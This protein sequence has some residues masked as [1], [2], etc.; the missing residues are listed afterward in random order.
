MNVWSEIRKENIHMNNSGYR[1]IIVDDEDIVRL[2]LVSFFEDEGFQVCSAQTGE[3]ALE[4]LMSQPCHVGIID[5]RLPKMDG[6][7]LILKAQ[8]INPDMK[9]LIHTGSVDYTLP[10]VLVTI[11]IGSEYVFV[12]PI[13]D[14]RLL[15]EALDRLLRGT[16]R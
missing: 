15:L 9:F 4:M 13:F 5:V 11:G 12:K 6:T 14:M 16:S 8:S 7:T 1:I 2:N 3:E 10:D